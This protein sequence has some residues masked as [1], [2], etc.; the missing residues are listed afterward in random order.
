MILVTG[1]T[2]NMGSVLVRKLTDLGHKVRVLTLKNDKF[3]SRIDGTGAEVRFGDISNPND[4]EGV[5][6]EVNTVIHLAAII[7]SDNPEVFKKINLDGT[8]YLTSEAKKAGVRHFIHIS[9]A[10]VLYEKH[11]PYSLSKQQ[12]EKVVKESGLSWTIIRPTL[13]YAEQGGQEFDMYLEYLDKYPI[14]PFIGDG[15]ALKRPVYVNDIINGL[16]K[17][18]AFDHGTNKIYNF[19]G[20]NVISML[21]F[22]RLCLLLMGKER[23]MILHIPVWVC[24]LTAWILGKIMKN[25]PIKWNA[26][27]GVIQDAN[28]DPADS[29]NDLGYAPITLNEMLSKCFPRKK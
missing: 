10:S 2:G 23:K 14:V 26:I 13:V 25:P 9:S 21:D 5:C 4:L 16:V 29:I 11:T 7:I 27:A 18:A 24:K 22:S 17:L 15:K 8:R 19:S 1:G 3:V 28:L 6:N 20:A 12:A